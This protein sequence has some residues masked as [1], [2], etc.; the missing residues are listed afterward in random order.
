MSAFRGS[1]ACLALLLWLSLAQAQK[2]PQVLT[3]SQLKDRE[4]SNRRAWGGIAGRSLCEPPR[5]VI[6]GV[7]L[8]GE[9]LISLKGAVAA[10]GFGTSKLRS[11]KVTGEL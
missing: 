5:G 11:W 8:A 10:N 6:V 9:A 3:D 7:W 1:W 4:F 2:A